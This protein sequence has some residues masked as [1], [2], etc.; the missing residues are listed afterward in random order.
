MATTINVTVDDMAL[1]I[2]LTVDDSNDTVSVTTSDGFFQSSGDQTFVSGF[3][4]I[5][6]AGNVA[7]TI[8]VNDYVDGWIG[9]TFVAGRVNTIPIT[10]AAHVDPAVQGQVF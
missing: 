1:I 5:K 2:N 4:L 7:A 9:T 6:G 8:E 10:S 3:R